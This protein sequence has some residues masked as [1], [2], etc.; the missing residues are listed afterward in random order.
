M[1]TGSTGTLPVDG[2]N[3]MV[4]YFVAFSRMEIQT[5]KRQL[6]G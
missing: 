3:D 6:Y 2:D 4:A 1:N 5:Y